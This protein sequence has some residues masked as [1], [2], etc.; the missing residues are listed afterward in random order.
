M[1]GGPMYYNIVLNSLNANVSK[2]GR[3]LIKRLACE[4]KDLI[5]AKTLPVDICRYATAE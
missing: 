3:E 5:D 4:N 1:M 2:K